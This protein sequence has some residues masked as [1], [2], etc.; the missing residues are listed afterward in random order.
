MP[1][2]RFISAEEQ[3]QIEHILNE[4]VKKS[5][6]KTAILLDQSGFLFSAQGNTD[7]I[8]PSMIAVLAAGAF[9]SAKQLAK[10]IHEEEFVMMFHQ[11]RKL[12]MYLSAVGDEALLFI[13]F[14]GST[15][16]TVN[17]FAREASKNLLPLLKTISNRKS[18][19]LRQGN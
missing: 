13:I 6:S 15:L 17:I 2:H 4:L 12:H 7:G 3:R 16:S 1:R 18:D 14:G 19:E 9:T 5:E 10:M 8:D 11:G